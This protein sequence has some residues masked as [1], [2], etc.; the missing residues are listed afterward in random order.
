[1]EPHFVKATLLRE[2]QA[3]KKE[4]SRLWKA[5]Q[6]AFDRKEEGYI[7]HALSSRLLNR[8]DL[9]Q[10]L[11]EYRLMAQF[12]EDPRR[13]F[14]DRFDEHIDEDRAYYADT[15]GVQV[16]AGAHRLPHTGNGET[17]SARD[18]A[19]MLALALHTAA[20]L[21]LADAEVGRAC[22]AMRDRLWHALDE[23]AGADDLGQLIEEGVVVY[24]EAERSIAVPTSYRMLFK[25]LNE[26]GS[27]L[28]SPEPPWPLPQGDEPGEWIKVFGPLFAHEHGLH[29]ARARDLATVLGAVLYEAETPQVVITEVDGVVVRRARLLRKV[30]AW[31]P[32]LLRQWAAACAQDALR[33]FEKVR[34]DDWRPR[35]AAETARSFGQGTVSIEQLDTARQ[36]AIEA[37][38]E[39]GVPVGGGH[40]VVQLA[41][42]DTGEPLE[43]PRFEKVRQELPTDPAA[44]KA[45]YEARDAALA[46]VWCTS[47]DAQGRLPRALA[48]RAAHA[49]MNAQVNRP[50]GVIGM[51]HKI[52]QYAQLLLDLLDLP[53]KLTTYG[54]EIWEVVPPGTGDKR[55][56]AKRRRRS[57]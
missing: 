51:R 33:H 28:F 36:A 29:L 53:V 4:H 48:R 34:P 49:A 35:E 5:H 31:T 11:V 42:S 18:L 26:D 30:D 37:V 20:V 12:R 2:Y 15:V 45:I 14:F 32:G 7:D 43:E 50:G 46:T 23:P 24:Q 8:A 52:W 9:R 57:T 40:A 13:S 25:F 10:D 39:L 27:A 55:P 19:A 44:L 3:A 56:R 54:E 6:A 41:W 22:L 1:M 38:N 16:E 47:R 17:L 21:H